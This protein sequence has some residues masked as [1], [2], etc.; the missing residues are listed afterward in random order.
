M[1]ERPVAESILKVFERRIRANP[2]VLVIYEHEIAK[3]LDASLY[4]ERSTAE[5]LIRAG[6][7]R[8]NGV[9]IKLER[10]RRVP[11]QGGREP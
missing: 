2:A 8:H 10:G 1:M 6:L 9:P 3:Y 7:A 5:A 11:G 4:G